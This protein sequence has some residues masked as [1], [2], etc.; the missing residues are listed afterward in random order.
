[1]VRIKGE[2]SDYKYNLETGNIHEVQPQPEH[3]Y[4][5]IFLCPYDHPSSVEEHQGEETCCQGTDHQCPEQEHGSSDGHALIRL[6]Q[7]QGISLVTDNHNQILVNQT[8]KIQL[9]PSSGGQVEVNGALVVQQKDGQ[10]VMLEI[11]DSGVF[12]QAVGG[13]KIHLDHQGNIDLFPAPGGKVRVNGDL[14]VT[15]K[16]LTDSVETVRTDEE[17]VSKKMQLIMESL[18]AVS[19]C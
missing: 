5:Q 17:E 7:K 8:G 10:N 4:L 19:S 6:D 13:A 12:I 14:E 1:M 16:V 15:G 3:L 2:N 11:S 18:H 9:S